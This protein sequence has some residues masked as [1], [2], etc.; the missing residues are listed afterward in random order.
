MV[1]SKVL[2]LKY[3][4][5]HHPALRIL[6]PR[7]LPALEQSCKLSAFGIQASQVPWKP[8]S[9]SLELVTIP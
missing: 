5:K 3:V 2:L 1:L 8:S 4:L 6:C 9:K 7:K